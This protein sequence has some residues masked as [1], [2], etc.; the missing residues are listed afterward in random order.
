MGCLQLEVHHNVDYNIPT[1]YSQISKHIP[2]HYLGS[3]Q[4]TDQI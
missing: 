3:L 1:D 4:L 2:Q